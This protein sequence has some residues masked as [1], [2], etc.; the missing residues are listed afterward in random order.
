MWFDVFV[1]KKYRFICLRGAGGDCLRQR[2]SI[3]KKC[4]K[5][6]SECF[7]GRPAGC[8]SKIWL[9]GKTVGFYLE[10]LVR[11]HVRGLKT[12]TL[13][14]FSYPHDAKFLVGF[15]LKSIP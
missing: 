13:R 7:L 6:A 14:Q 5:K 12:H 2:L 3:L 4:Y 9:T 8:T 1:V 15:Q 11:E 10:A